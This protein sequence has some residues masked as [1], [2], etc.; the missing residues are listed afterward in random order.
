MKLPLP[1]YGR[2][3]DYISIIEVIAV[4]INKIDNAVRSLTKDKNMQFHGKNHLIQ[5]IMV[6]AGLQMCEESFKDVEDYLGEAIGPLLR[7]FGVHHE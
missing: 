5:M 4:Y 1:T 2:F 7:D 6:T 3:P